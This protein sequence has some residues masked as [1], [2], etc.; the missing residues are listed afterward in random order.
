[1]SIESEIF[2]RKKANY[3]QLIKYGFIKNDDEYRYTVYF[4]NDDFFADILVFENR[5]SGKVYDALTNEEYVNFRIIGKL[6][7][8]ASKVK[9]AYLNILYDIEKKCFSDE[10]FIF[11]QSNRLAKYIFKKYKDDP[12]FS[13]DRNPGFG[14]FKNSISQK[15]YALIMNIDRSKIAEGHGEIEIINLK[16]EKH[17][18]KELLKQEGYYK[19][20]H[21]NKE[22][23]I[24]IILDE[25]L[26]DDII[27]KLIDES[28]SYTVVNISREWIIPANPKYYDIAKAF[29]LN[30]T[31]IWNQRS[32]I[33]IDDI[34]YIYMT[35]PIAA[36]IYKCKATE[37]DIPY[38]N[39]KA[40]YIKLLQ[41]YD[42][43]LYTLDIMKKYEVKTVRGVRYM[44]QKLSEYINH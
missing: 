17:K 5:V 21:M 11:N 43:N 1:M 27:E 3:K 39:G 6:G 14:V 16:L 15:W 36:I 37:V 33:Q 23:W 2:K 30:D 31:I 12:I 41:V 18:I 10:Y 32:H 35:K 22:S 20:Y 7:E 25:T 29:Q 24:S 26:S 19:A 4:M 28:Y 13:L 9:E 34:I 44:P 40:M 38:K 42:E 8:Y